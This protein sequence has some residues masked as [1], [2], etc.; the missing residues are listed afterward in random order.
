MD[1]LN[2]AHERDESSEV[3]QKMVDRLKNLGVISISSVE[4]AFRAVPRH[5]FVPKVEMK[6]AYTNEAIM[7]KEQDGHAISSSSQPSIMA[8]MLEMLDLQTGQR[9]LEIGAGTGYNAALMAHIVGESG[10][11]VT[12]DIDEDI[13]QDA[14]DHLWAAGIENARVVRGDGGLGWAEGAPYDRVILTA[15]TADIPP[16]WHEQL[17]PGGRLVLP[18][19]L[20]SSHSKLARSPVMPDQFV[21]ALTWTGEHFEC[22]DFRPCEFMALRGDFAQKMTKVSA[23]EAETGISALLPEEINAR[24]LFALLQ[25]PAQDELTDVHLAFQ[26]AFGLRLWLALSDPRYCEVYV[27]EG[28]EAGAIPAQLRRDTTFSAALGLCEQETCCLLLLQEEE[29]GW[30]ANPQ[31]PFRLAI[32][33]F[34]EDQA[35]AGCLRALVE[36]WDQADH[37]FVWSREGRMKN[38]QIRAF[39]LE[40][41]YTPSSFEIALIRPHTRFIFTSPAMQPS[42]SPASGEL[43]SKPDYV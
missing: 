38:L 11:V 30:P 1:A 17:R 9:V 32:R 15:S 39:P 25:R 2:G 8:I 31:R 43:P 28:A 26:E 18:F 5:L 13:V 6:A 35:L 24:D 21:L 3:R 33:R 14:R 16:A 29:D 22:L 19:Q 12:V 41:P 40:K 42:Q 27:K 20:T 36:A 34:G 23:P 7:T 10:Q 4:Q 37:P